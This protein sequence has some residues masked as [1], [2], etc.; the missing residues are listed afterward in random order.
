MPNAPHI[1]FAQNA[2]NIGG[3][4]EGIKKVVR[5][6]TSHTVTLLLR[7]HLTERLRQT[8]SVTFNIL[9]IMHW[10]W[11]LITSFIEMKEF[12]SNFS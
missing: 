1:Y 2:I 12:W 4:I 11:K 3:E 6:K 9:L 7:N 10:I 8:D 5:V